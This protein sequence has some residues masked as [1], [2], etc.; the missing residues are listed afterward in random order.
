MLLPLGDR[1]I[2][3]DGI[4]H[5][6]T[7]DPLVENAGLHVERLGRD[8]QTFGDLLHD[9]GARATQTALDLTEVGIRN[10]GQLRELPHRNLRR[11]PL[12]ADELAEVKVL[13]HDSS[14]TPTANYCKRAG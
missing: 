13:G 12:L 1:G 4:D 10:A 5:R 9:L 3:D 7:D 14:V 8:A 6:A 11:A 2:G